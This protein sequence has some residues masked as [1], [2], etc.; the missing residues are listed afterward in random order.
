MQQPS[1]VDLASYVS[2]THSW[3]SWHWHSV[4]RWLLDCWLL[5]TLKS[6]IW[7]NNKI[8]DFPDLREYSDSPKIQKFKSLTAFLHVA[9]KVIKELFSLFIIIQ[10]IQL[11]QRKKFNNV[12]QY[13]TLISCSIPVVNLFTLSARQVN[14]VKGETCE[15]EETS[16]RLLPTFIN[17]QNTSYLVIRE[18]GAFT[19]SRRTHYFI[20]Y[21]AEKG[22]SVLAAMAESAILLRSLCS[23]RMLTLIS[24]HTPTSCLQTFLPVSVAPHAATF[25]SIYRLRWTDSL[26]QRSILAHVHF[27]VAAVVQGALPAAN[28]ATIINGWYY[29]NGTS[30]SNEHRRP[31]FMN[32]LILF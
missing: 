7:K 29:T 24:P 3:A 13:L 15:A 25:D 17:L 32:D 30:P 31:P 9:E 4:S 2:S 12:L 11:K 1:H 26:L 14:D 22:D 18:A 28:A 6:S 27:I 16:Q 21:L 20:P 23:S 8:P 5:L 19:S 10:F